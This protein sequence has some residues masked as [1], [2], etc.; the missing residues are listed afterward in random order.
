MSEMPQRIESRKPQKKKKSSSAARETGVSRHNGVQI[1]VL[2]KP[3]NIIA[4]TR[5]LN[6]SPMMPRDASISCRVTYA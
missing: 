4:M 6:C 1:E 2:L 5:S 3:L